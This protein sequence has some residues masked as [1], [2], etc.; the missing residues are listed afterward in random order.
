[1]RVLLIGGNGFIGS[2]L[3]K[4]LLAAGHTIALFHRAQALGND[5]N[6]LHISG[7]RN[8][9]SAYREQ[10]QE[11]APDVIVDLILSSGEQG[12]ELMS[13]ARGITGRVVALS[14]GDVYRAWGVLH[15]VESGALEPLPITEDS[16]LRTN[17]QLYSPETIRM[18]KSIFPWA[19][20][21][22]DKIAVEEAVMGTPGVSGTVLRLPMIY[23]PGDL[24]H[25][26]FPVLKP[27]ADGRPSMILPENLAAWRGPRGYVE[28]VAH[29]IALAIATD[30]AAER[31]YNICEEPCISEL[32]WRTGI[33]EQ[34]G[35][36]GKFVVLPVEHTPQHLLF[37]FNAAQQVVVSSQRIRSELG[38]EEIVSREAGIRRTIA[39]E[40]SNP[41][42]TVNSKQFDYAAED[43]ALSNAA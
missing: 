38:Y 43:A 2:P 10:L 29:A 19:T 4:Q 39:W 5:R 35:W 8:R 20:E 3:T 28:N 9:L 14:T 24:A 34:A 40:F 21:D 33:A 41:P 27:I 18:M 6:V 7:D 12:R 32:E 42:Q 25:R 16:P 36:T 31:I 13:V 37:Q 23:G 22:Y 17:R 15:G 26:F 30:A 11:F 1:M